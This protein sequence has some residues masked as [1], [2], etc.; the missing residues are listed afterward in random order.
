LLEAALDLFVEHGYAATR[1]E[2]VAQRAGVSKGTLFRY[3]PS[4]EA[5]FQ[6][7]VR[8]HLV[9]L[10]DE[11]NTVIDDHPGSSAD[12][13]RA[14]LLQWWQRVGA[15]RQSGITKLVLTE[16]GQF[17]EL[18]AF[19]QQEVM[20]RGH[21]LLR[22]ILT[23]GVANGEFRALDLEHAIHVLTA[24]ML[25]LVMWKH[26]LAPCVASPQVLDP[27]RFVL[28]QVDLVLHGLLSGTPSPGSVK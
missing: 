16:A 28:T 5:L 4:K 14:S 25:F 9:G 12:L 15:T 17:P 23:R 6:A 8:Q 27:E 7:V 3:F 20:A 21:A 2:A 24:P 11:W 13:V 18:G 10:L 26:A 19:Y 22:R 1:V